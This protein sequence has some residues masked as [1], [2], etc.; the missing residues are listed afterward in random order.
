[1]AISIS[2][3]GTLKGDDV[4]YPNNTWEISC[5]QEE[6]KCRVAEAKEIGFRQLGRIDVSDWTITAWNATTVTADEGDPSSC[7]HN[8]IVLNRIAKTVAYTSSPQNQDKDYC[9]GYNKLIG[10]RTAGTYN[11]EIGKPKQPWE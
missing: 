4:G 8:L 6:M 10:Q 2:I 7:A 3:T 11:W 9:T 1:M 5:Y